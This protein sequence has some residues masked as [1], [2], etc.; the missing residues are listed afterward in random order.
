MA[1]L[2][3][4]GLCAEDTGLQ[5]D[6]VLDAPFQDGLCQ[7]GSVRGGTAQ[8]G[9]AQ[10]F[11]ELELTVG[12]AGG[13]GEGQGAHLVGAAVET[14]TAGEQTVAVGHVDHVVL[15]AAG[16]HDGTGA[17]VLPQVH[18]V[19]GV[20]GHHALAGGAGGGVD[21]DAFAQGLCHEAVGVA[22]AKV[23][24]GDEGELVQVLNALDVI[25]GH[26]F[27]FHLL[28][29][30]GDV[31]PHM[32]D[33]LH[34]TFTLEGTKLVLGY[35]FDFGLIHCHSNHSFSYDLSIL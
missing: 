30:V 16:C 33:L 10:V 26:S 9:G 22:L 24:L 4:P 6:V 11:H 13:H 28:A 35:G 8:D 34:Q 14:G 31:V 27:G 20:V 12:V 2:F 5:L 3:G 15:G 23:I 1:H 19:L 21:A 7:E 32:L 25:G 18:V 29:V 17:A